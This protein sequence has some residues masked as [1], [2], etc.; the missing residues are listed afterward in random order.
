VA[1]LL[2]WN[3]LGHRVKSYLDPDNGIDIEQK[4]FPILMVASLLSVSDEE[5]ED[6]ITDGSKDR[7]VEGSMPFLLMI[8]MAGIHY[9]YSS[10]NMSIRSIIQ[11]RIFLAAK[12]IN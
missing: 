3:T 2:D 4:A 6:S 8:E 1:N 9:M 11:K 7:G 12:L 10:S 5:A